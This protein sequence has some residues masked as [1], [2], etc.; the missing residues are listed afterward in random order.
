MHFGADTVPDVFFNYAVMVRLDKRRDRV[1]DI[2]DM[3]ADYGS[4]DACCER[5][6]RNVQKLLRF[7]TDLA[8]RHCHR[9]I[10]HKS[11]FGNHQIQTD[12]ISLFE[13]HSFGG[14][15][16]HYAFIHRNTNRARKSVIPFA[17]RNGSLLNNVFFRYLI[18]F[19]GRNTGN[20]F[21]GE[22]LQCLRG[23]F[24]GSGNALDL[25]GG[26]QNDHCPSFFRRLNVL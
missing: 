8:N 13:N 14:D 5:P 23:N 10:A 20:R 3:V 19:P 12:D 1:T 11:V 22:Q 16:M 24:A 7:R 26:S 18:Q 15:A 2:T 9:S 4:G 21:T 6:L 17:F 25:A